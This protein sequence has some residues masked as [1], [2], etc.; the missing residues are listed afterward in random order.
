MLLL[1]KKGSGSHVSVGGAG[2]YLTALRPQNTDLP[3]LMDLPCLTDPEV[4]LAEMRRLWADRPELRTLCSARATTAE[5]FWP[6][7]TKPQA[8]LRMR[9]SRRQPPRPRWTPPSAA[10][11]S[12]RRPAP[13]GFRN[14]AC[15]R[16][17]SRSR[18]PR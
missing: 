2:Q 10:P 8:Q 9:R 1:L 7:S 12:A 16:L 14:G 4:R 3:W 15:T 17:R 6:C 5:D 11:A 18:P 13:L